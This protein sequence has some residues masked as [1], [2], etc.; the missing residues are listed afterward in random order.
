M[1]LEFYLLS[2]DDWGEGLHTEERFPVFVIKDDT[3][4]HLHGVRSDL[5]G[6]VGHERSHRPIERLLLI[7]FV[8]I[9]R[10]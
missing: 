2:A 4:M 7:V 1:G 8:Q 10:L 9:R 5:G 3:L 6:Q